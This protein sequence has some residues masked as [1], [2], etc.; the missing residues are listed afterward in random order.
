[1]KLFS[2]YPGFRWLW[3]GQLLS[4]L[5]NAVFYILGLWEI[6]LKSPFCCP[7]RDWR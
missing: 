5:G 6:Q 1:M 2:R 3:T 7:L 4:Q